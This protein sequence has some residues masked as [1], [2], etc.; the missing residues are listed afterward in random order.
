M[1]AAG[2]RGSGFKVRIKPNAQMKPA[3]TA[4]CRL[5]LALCLLGS[6]SNTARAQ[7]AATSPTP[8]DAR[9]QE[10]ALK[11]AKKAAEK[12]SAEMKAAVEKERKEAVNAAQKRAK[13]TPAQQK[14]AELP[15]AR[16]VPEVQNPEIESARKAE[17]KAQAEAEKARRKEEDRIRA[18][19]AREAER[20]RKDE[21]RVEREA[22]K[23]REREEKARAEAERKEAQEAAKSSG[24]DKDA[25]R[26]R[27]EP[28]ARTAERTA[29]RPDP[30]I[31]GD[32][33]KRRELVRQIERARAERD[34]LNQKAAEAEQLAKAA[35]AAVLESQR[36]L[37]ALTTGLDLEDVTPTPASPAEPVAKKSRFVTKADVIQTASPKDPKAAADPLRV[38]LDLKKPLPEERERAAFA[39]ASLGPEAQPATRALMAALA[40]TSAAVRTAAAQAL[41]R[42]GPGAA[43][44]IAPL[45]AALSDPDPA[46][47]N[48]AQ[49][50]LIA[51]QG[52]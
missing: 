30:A 3:F 37:E 2:K 48:A 20:R 43:T 38:A 51:I 26:E 22:E 44:A 23:A 41:G 25:G 52:R 35:R 42:I 33:R 46:V 29:A 49:A 9:A 18:E 19:D 16:P 13:A 34:R 8:L 11:D 21:E 28:T 31:Q 12:E 7:G 1:P 5:A 27:T 14:P 39:L 10:R 32:D 17:A 4:V 6:L 15:A 24:A 36:A 47:K 40:D 45:S 50:A